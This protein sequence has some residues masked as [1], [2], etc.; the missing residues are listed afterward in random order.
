MKDVLDI[1]DLSEAEITELYDLTDELKADPDAFGDALENESLV[2]LFAKPSTRT[3]ISFESGMTELGGHAIHFAEE[4]SQ[5]SRGESLLDT[6]TVLS[7]YAGGIM[8]RLFDHETLL[9]L[10]AGADVP[11]IN[12][13]TD[14]LH[15][16]Q[17]LADGY[18]LRE[19][20]LLDGPLAYVGDGNNVA[21]S[22]M[23]LCAT[24]DIP[25]RIATPDGYEPDAD[26]QERVA[27]A[28]VLVTND[29]VEAVQ[30]ARAVYTDVFVSMGED[31]SKRAD[32][33][34][35]QVTEELMAETDDAAFMHCLPAHRG[36]EVSAAVMDGPNSI[37]YDQAE[38]RKHVQKA[39]L[40]T[41]YE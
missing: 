20:G 41:V 36:E 35:F 18:T 23:Q 3:R 14:K 15:P 6:A 30:G 10:A 26:I 11:V 4:S 27:D 8:A 32:F 22:L 16:C 33:E 37:V 34:G 12:G 28:D 38:N 13:L 5:I 21:H 1:D 39:I 24:L 9:E 19:K 7:R 31:D 29:P 2:M 17:A 25:C 40:E